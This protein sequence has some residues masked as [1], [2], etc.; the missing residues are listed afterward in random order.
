MIEVRLG[1]R[2]LRVPGDPPYPEYWTLA[3]DIVARGGGAS[4]IY[5]FEAQFAQQSEL[6]AVS[7]DVAFLKKSLNLTGLLPRGSIDVHMLRILIS[8]AEGSI[9]DANNMPTL[10]TL[11]ADLKAVDFMGN[12]SDMDDDV[13]PLPLVRGHNN[14]D[15][16]NPRGCRVSRNFRDI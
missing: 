3:D 6:E 9:Y 13:G 15:Q 14:I 2:P 4:S 8:P 7:A 12:I 11:V 10:R 5:M 16:I 1:D